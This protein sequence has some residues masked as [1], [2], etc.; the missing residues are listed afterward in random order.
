[1]E[2][3]YPVVFAPGAFGDLPKEVPF[4][5]YDADG[6]RNIL[7]QATV[8][9]GDKGLVV[10]VRLDAPAPWIVGDALKQVSAGFDPPVERD[11]F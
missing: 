4:V 11:E 5:V 8:R 7:G 10:D 9:E 2:G 6:R 3:D 1:M